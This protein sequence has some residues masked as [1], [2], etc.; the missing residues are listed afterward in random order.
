M[1]RHIAPTAGVLVRQPGATDVVELFQD[2][3]VDALLGQLD[4]GPDPAEAGTD[5]DDPMM[6]H[7]DTL[8]ASS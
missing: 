8:A 1:R 5:D 2:D 6:L 3:V 7:H 4:R